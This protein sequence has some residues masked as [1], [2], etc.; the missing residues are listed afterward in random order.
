MST[1][2]PEPEG[3][4]RNEQVGEKNYD[5]LA[6]LLSVEF[7]GQHRRLFRIRINC[8]IGQQLAQKGFTARTNLRCRGAVHATYHFGQ[9]HGRK[10]RVLITSRAN[11]PFDQSSNSFSAPFRADDYAG[12]EDQSHS[13]GVSGSRWLSTAA[14]TSR[15]DL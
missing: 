2:N 14:S 9:A 7:P 13:G 4:R 12:I 15:T 1:E 3:R 5:T 11:D 8:E 6:L 10:G